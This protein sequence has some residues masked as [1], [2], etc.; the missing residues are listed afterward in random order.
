MIKI[1]IVGIVIA[2]VLAVGLGITWSV[3]GI[4]NHSFIDLKHNFDEAV[5]ALPDGTI[6]SGAVQS[7]TD[8]EDSDCVQIKIDGVVYLT[9]YHNATIIRYEGN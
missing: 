2:T 7:W 9:H 6:V 1:I 4:G 8:Y 3:I 5:I